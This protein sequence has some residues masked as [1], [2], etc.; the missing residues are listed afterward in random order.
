MHVRMQVCGCRHLYIYI[1]IYICIDNDRVRVYVFCFAGWQANVGNSDV[2]AFHL[3]FPAGR[4]KEAR[5][6]LSGPPRAH[7]F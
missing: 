3:L 5:C 4:P 6:G 7:G 1:H 2:V